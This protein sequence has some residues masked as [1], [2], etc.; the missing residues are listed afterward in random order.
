MKPL[1]RDVG[2]WLK[3]FTFLLTIL[4]LLSPLHNTQGMI[5]TSTGQRAESLRTQL[6]DLANKE[7]ALRMRLEQLEVELQP[8]SLQNRTA[9]TGTLDAN[10]LREQLRRELEGEKSK[11]QQQLEIL[12][13]SRARLESSL[14]EAEAETVRRSA[15][16][17]APTNSAVMT[18]PTPVRASQAARPLSPP[19]KAKR[20]VVRLSRR[21]A[22][23]ARRRHR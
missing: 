7:A 10:A 13:A 17:L 3:R 16:A 12:A 4:S 8:E 21:R 23:N 6:S 19:V 22:S 9:L 5:S 20:Q 1:R 14:A 15:D 2:L 11:A 18:P